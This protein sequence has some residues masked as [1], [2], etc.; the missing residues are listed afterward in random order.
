MYS[1]ILISELSASIEHNQLE[2]VLPHTVHILLF[3]WLP[4]FIKIGL[5]LNEQFIADIL[6]VTFANTVSEAF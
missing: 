3:F 6:F 2:G 5:S 4:N 1:T